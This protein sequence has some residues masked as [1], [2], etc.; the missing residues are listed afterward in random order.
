MG[1][2][3][4]KYIS[5]N[6]VRYDYGGDYMNTWEDD[7]I[8]LLGRPEAKYNNQLM[9]NRTPQVNG[10]NLKQSSSNPQVQSSGQ[11]AS[12]TEGAS[13]GSAVT[14][15]VGT[16][17]PLL[18]G[19]LDATDSGNEYGRQK[20]GTVIGKGAL[21]GAT[22]GAAL[23]PVGIAA[24]AVLGA[25]AGIISSGKQ[26]KAEEKMLY[27]KSLRDKKQQSEYS[28]AQLAA[29]PS[30]YQG[31][32]DSEYFK[33]GG[34]IKRKRKFGPK[35]EYA[36]P[37]MM[38]QIAKNGY[39]LGGS[40]GGQEVPMSSDGSEIMGN[41]HQEGGVK[42]PGMGVELEDG[43]TVKGDYVFSKKL[44]FAQLHKPI[45]RAKGKIE[46]KPY[47]AGR[48]NSIRLLNE[49]ENRL[50]LSQEYL[51]NKYGITA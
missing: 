42:F 38:E 33:Y 46:A 29:N 8:A 48:A 37:E 6:Y 9:P 32:I 12:A 15:A 24:G 39:E 10:I 16:L 1:K 26:K 14:G 21:T 4:K 27:E 34:Q 31:Y 40:M 2:L 13:K 18:G 19:I 45:M 47:T 5:K 44:G 51:K 22:A 35:S 43:E 36:P 20:R 41:S 17:A 49:Q 3:S 11:S 23:G 28:A 7:R 30:L 50:K 25:T